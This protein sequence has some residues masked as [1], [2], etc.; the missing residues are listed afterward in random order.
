MFFIFP[1]DQEG[2][3]MIEIVTSVAVIGIMAGVFLVNYGSNQKSSELILTAQKMVSDIRIAQNN[4]LAFLDIEEGASGWGFY[5]SSSSN[6]YHIFIDQ[7]GDYLYDMDEAISPH[8]II[9]LP[10]D[11]VIQDMQVLE[12]GIWNSVSELNI[13]FQPPDPLTFIN[14]VD[15]NSTRIMIGRDGGTNFET[16]EVNFFGLIDVID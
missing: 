4:S 2:F 8:Q 12:S 10:S 16:I 1:K 9:N 15:T 11:V 3:S 5:A 13:I 14:G 6:S 7:D